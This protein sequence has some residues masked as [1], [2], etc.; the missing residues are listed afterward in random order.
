[1][2]D[3]HVLSPGFLTTMQDLGRYGQAHR[4]ISASGARGRAR[5]SRRES[6]GGQCGKCGRA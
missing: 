2:N 3:L 4:G 6:L 5:P 1:M